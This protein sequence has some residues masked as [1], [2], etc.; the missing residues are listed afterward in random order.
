[1][2]ARF[3][4]GAPLAIAAGADLPRWFLAKAAGMEQAIPPLG[5]YR[6][7]LYMTRFDDSF[8]LTSEDLRNAARRGV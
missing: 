8:L 6:T 5:T 7:D 3:A 1:V 2:N 4:G